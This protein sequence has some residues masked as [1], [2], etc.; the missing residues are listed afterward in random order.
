MRPI[1]LLPPRYQRARATGKRSGI[2]YAA[3]GI[4]A[5]LLLMLVLYVVTTNGIS[6]AHDQTAKAKAEQQTADARVA[7]LQAFGDF[8]SMKASRETAVE[9]VADARFDY[10]RVMREMALVLPH[11]TYLTNFTAATSGDSSAASGAAATTTAAG[12]ATSSGPSLTVNG[13]A[14]SHQGVATAVVRLRQLHDVTDVN[15]SNSTKGGGAGATG[16]SASSGGAGCKVSWAATLSFQPEA[17][18]TTQQPVPARLGGG[19]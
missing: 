13:C 12:T 2:A 5:V 4:M 3:V 18:Q 11:N 16:S 8:A 6:D 9:G 19:Q 7:D 14:P 10:E 15:L 17:A 1:N